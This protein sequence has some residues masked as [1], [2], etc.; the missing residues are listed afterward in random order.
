M[1][2][3]CRTGREYFDIHPES[4]FGLFCDIIFCLSWEY[5]VSTTAMLGSHPNASRERKYFCQIVK[6]RWVRVC[7]HSNSS[8]VG[9]A[10]VHTSKSGVEYENAIQMHVETLGGTKWN[11]W[12]E[13]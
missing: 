6:I 5:S 12:F 4:R 11:V 10:Y 9:H 13:I 1:Q 8:C 2:P 7:G 3:C